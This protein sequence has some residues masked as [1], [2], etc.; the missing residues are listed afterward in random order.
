M[1]ILIIGLPSGEQVTSLSHSIDTDEALIGQSSSCQI[2]LPDNQKQVAERHALISREDDHW[3]LENL[4]SNSLLVNT[5]ELCS[6]SR[7]RYLLTDGDVIAC[8]EY[9]LMVSDFSPWQA[10]ITTGLETPALYSKTDR[11][12][13]HT[14]ESC[15]NPYA[16]SVSVQEHLD[17]PFEQPDPPILQQNIP[18]TAEVSMKG[19]ETSCHA[20][21]QS[22]LID[23]L[24]DE[25]ADDDQDWS[26]NRHLR[27]DY[28]QLFITKAK[29]VTKAKVADTVPT[30]SEM[31]AL[32][33]TSLKQNST[34]HRSVCRAMLRSL[35]LFMQD[36]SPEKLEQQFESRSKAPANAH[37]TASSDYWSQYQHFYRQMMNDQ[38][39][40][41]L[42][43]HRFRQALKQQE[44]HR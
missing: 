15:T 14:P 23:V 37:R 40:Q 22:S 26:I 28:Q 7:Q 32:Q 6:G 43:L 30:L 24:A 21:G 38:R 42:F 29:A 8:G 35:E 27:A 2:L 1:Q 31:A 34:H 10:S 17:D 16:E 13:D 33:E 3:Y 4:S 36:L 20:E 12:T 25:T 41:L 9:R 44:Q 5:T 39:Y 11:K 18:I 19:S